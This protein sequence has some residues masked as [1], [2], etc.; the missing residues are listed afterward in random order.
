MA[1]FVFEMKKEE[2][3]DAKIF[4]FDKEENRIDSYIKKHLSKDELE[5]IDVLMK[6]EGFPSE[7]KDMFVASL[8]SG[9]IIFVAYGKEDKSDLFF[10]KMGGKMAKALFTSKNAVFYTK[11][12]MQA[13]HFAFG[14]ELGSYRFNKYFTKK[15]KEFYSSLKT[16]SFVSEKEKLN[17]KEYDAFSALA[18]SVNYTRDLV[19][20]PANVLTPATYVAELKKLKKAGLDIE[21]LDEKELKK[22]GFNLLLAVGE[23]SV[24]KPYVVIIKWVGNKKKKEF[25]L[26]LVGKGVT[27]DTGG[28]NI[29]TGLGLEY[30][31][32]DMG[33][34]AVVAGTL[35]ALALSKSKANVIGFMGLV[36]NSIAGNAMRVND[37]VTSMSGQTVEIMNTDAEGRLVLADLLTYAQKKYKVNRIVDL[38]TLTGAILVALGKL[39]TGLF[40]NDDGFAKD[41]LKSGENADEKLWHMPVDKYFD[42]MMDSKIA[43]MKNIGT[44]RLGGSSQAACFLQRFIEKDV[45]W[46]HLDIAGTV[47]EDKG[48]ELN[49][50]GPTGVGVRLLFDYVKNNV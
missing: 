44:G 14:Y 45:K 40:S 6:R 19:N 26:A 36:E 29:K 43:D 18:S 9:K 7:K 49:P 30:M 15:D 34:S 12:A 13:Y 37:I 5:M 31:N 32:Y 41:L 23:A 35:R 47:D 39:Y 27:F 2:N 21:I 8:K 10:Q 48:T 16:L 3:F 1:K 33:G 28:V 38:A 22:L 17:D 25:D 11:N 50:K 20:E 46:S 42:K 24:N 4:L